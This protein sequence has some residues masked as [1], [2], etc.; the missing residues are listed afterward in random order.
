MTTSACGLLMAALPAQAGV[1]GNGYGQKPIQVTQQ[2][3]SAC[4]HHTYC[5]PQQNW[6]PA[7]Y[8]QVQKQVWIPGKAK[9]VWVQ[10]VYE[11]HCGIFG[12]TYQVLVSGGHFVTQSTPGHNQIVNQNVLV[13]GKWVTSCQVIA[14]PIPYSQVRGNLRA[15]YSAFQK[16]FQPGTKFQG[17]GAYG[18]QGGANIGGYV[19]HGKQSGASIG[20]YAGNSGKKGYGGAVSKKKGGANW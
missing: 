7:H 12:I 10:P 6:V 1:F 17:Y 2:V 11:Q 14:A 9:Q 16:P 15:Q 4:T 8:K 19:M 5:V 13:T 20:G 18:K 3:P